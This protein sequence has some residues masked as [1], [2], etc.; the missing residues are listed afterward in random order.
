MYKVQQYSTNQMADLGG[1]DPYPDPTLEIQIQA[2]I[3]PGPDPDPILENQPRLPDPTSFNKSF[4]RPLFKIR[5]HIRP[6][7]RGDPAGSET[8]LIA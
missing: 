3:I 6:K 5:I 8:L 7:H 2:S 4:I 1:V